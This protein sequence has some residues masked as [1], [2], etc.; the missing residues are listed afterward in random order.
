MKFKTHAKQLK[1]SQVAKKKEAS[2]H[3]F[4]DIIRVGDDEEKAELTDIQIIPGTQG[5]GESVLNSLGEFIYDIDFV[6]DA[7]DALLDSITGVEFTIYE[8]RPRHRPRVKGKSQSSIKAAYK[9][10]KT[11]RSKRPSLSS[12]SVI[13]RRERVISRATVRLGHEFKKSADLKRHLEQ[14]N[15][16]SLKDAIPEEE[17]LIRTAV[18]K[19]DAQ[20]LGLT[21]T[22]ATPYIKTDQYMMSTKSRSGVSA[23]LPSFNRATSVSSKSILKEM[24]KAGVSAISSGGSLHPIMPH[25][26]SSGRDSHVTTD[27]KKSGTSH[28]K[29]RKTTVKSTK[30]GNSVA[31][32]KSR[33][34]HGPIPSAA[35]AMNRSLMSSTQRKQSSREEDLGVIKFRTRMI[36]YSLSLGVDIKKA[37]IRDK[38]VMK[39]QLIHDRNRKGAYRFYDI[40]HREQVDDML[41]PVHSPH[42]SAGSVGA[43]REVRL[44]ITQNDDVATS[45][46]LLRRKITEDRADPEY[47]FKEVA[48]LRVQS[49]TGMMMYMDSDVTVVHPVSYEYRVYPIGPT[50]IA[51]PQLSSAVI[52]KGAAPFVGTTAGSNYSS[53]DDNIA[54]SAV[55]KYDRIGLTIE[56]IPDDVIAIRLYKEDLKSD[57]FFSNSESRFKPVIPPDQKSSIINVGKGVTSVNIEDVDVVPNHTYKYK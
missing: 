3:S 28:V 49:E 57:S 1:R 44:C 19:F 39:V 12:S 29:V 50:G 7:E 21:V 13:S 26:L 16:K 56:S 8:E 34:R 18:P 2:K 35:V 38:L 41:T 31:A 15:F 27:T 40:N 45:V 23:K 36:A 37:G 24:E 14:I 46:T 4:S 17:V 42:I 32:R 33:P 9:R 48:D 11:R 43:S 47:R 25:F 54:I 6:I 55:N 53:T 20:Q 51:A 10:K 22:K 5:S 52:V 30:R